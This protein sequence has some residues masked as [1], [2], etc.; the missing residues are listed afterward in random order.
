METLDYRGDL[1]RANWSIGTRTAPPT[2]LTVHY[3]GGPVAAFGNP[4]AE[5]AQL[6]EDARWQMRPDWPGKAGGADGLQYHEAVLSH[7]LVVQTRNHADQLWHCA[8]VDGN[9]HSLSLHLPL[10]GA[11]RPTWTQWAALTR[12]MDQLID[13]YAMPGGRAAVKGHI[14]WPRLD[15]V[16][17]SRCPGAIVMQMLADWRNSPRQYWYRT[18]A[19]QVRIRTAPTTKSPVALDGK[20]LLPIRRELL[21]NKLV[22]G[23]KVSQLVGGRRI[24]TNVWAELADKLGYVWVG[25]LEVYA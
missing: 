10:G 3:N 18:L 22:D 17:Q 25:N 5:L 1:P 4:R 14:E 8:N 2:H 23:E 15:G 20:A 24:I 19:D 6:Y 16:P 7:G 21:V 9:A 12:R 13:L 11:Q